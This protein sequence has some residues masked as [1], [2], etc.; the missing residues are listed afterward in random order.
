MSAPMPD[1][2]KATAADEAPASAPQA[3]PKSAPRSAR[4]RALRRLRRAAV[5]ALLGVGWLC[6]VLA[7]A[8]FWLEKSGTLNR[9]VEQ[10]LARRLGPIAG[11]I[12]VHEKSLAYVYQTDPRQIGYDNHVKLL[13]NGSGANKLVRIFFVKADLDNTPRNDSWTYDP[14]LDPQAEDLWGGAIFITELFNDNSNDR[15]EDM[16]YLKTNDTL[17][18][19]L[20]HVLMQEENHYAGPQ[21]SF[22]SALQG[23]AFQGFAF[24]RFLSRLCGRLRLFLCGGRRARSFSAS[25]LG[26]YVGEMESTVLKQGDKFCEVHV[27]PNPGILIL[28][29]PT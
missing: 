2:P 15:Y 6:F 20:G 13:N 7:I 25:C 24:Q 21:R 27:A 8:A 26:N 10:E 23:S 19:E 18:H 11:E 28:G 9:W 12:H 4:A 3:A 16:G 5:R 29:S 14:L 1:E 17:L 22:V